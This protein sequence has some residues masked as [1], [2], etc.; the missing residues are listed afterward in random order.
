MKN[1]LNFVASIRSLVL[2]SSADK[3]NQVQRNAMKADA[4]KALLSDLADLNAVMTNDGIVLPVEND[5]LGVVYVEI[6]LKVKNLDFDLEN[7]VAEYEKTLADRAD[8]VKERAEKKAK[9]LAEKA[10]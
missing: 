2:K 9:A 3:I 6:D 10:K 1:I 7:A 4:M 5:E 8:R